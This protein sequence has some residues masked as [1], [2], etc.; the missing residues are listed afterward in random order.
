MKTLRFAGAVA[1]V[2]FLAGCGSTPGVTLTG[3]P[4]ADFAPLQSKIAGFTDADVAAA[5]ADAQANGDV[6]AQTC[7]GIVQ[8]ALPVLKPPAGAG[9]ATAIQLARDV[10]RQIPGISDACAGILPTGLAALGGL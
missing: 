4:I 2:L 1:L 7:W 8:K 5:L 6:V 10:Q 3:N 9:A